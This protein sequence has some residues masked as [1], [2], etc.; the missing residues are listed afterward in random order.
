[1]SVSA[2]DNRARPQWGILP[3]TRARRRSGVDQASALAHRTGSP[4][5]RPPTDRVRNVDRQSNGPALQ[6]WPPR[7]AVVIGALGLHS[8][9]TR[10]LRPGCLD[11]CG[12]DRTTRSRPQPYRSR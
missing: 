10:A 3:S 1:M 9:G 6:P 12:R 5:R 11:D 7:D 4:G 8:G 2:S